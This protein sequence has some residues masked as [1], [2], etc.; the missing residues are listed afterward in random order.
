MKNLLVLIL[1]SIIAF[2]CATTEKPTVIVTDNSDE[3]IEL[4]EPIEEPRIKKDVFSYKSSLRWVGDLA[5]AANCVVNKKSFEDRVRAVRS[6]DFSNSNGDEVYN[7]LINFKCVA[8]TY[9][10]RWYSPNRTKVIATTWTNERNGNFYL[11]LRVHPRP[12]P[13]MINTAIHECLHKVGYSH[14]NNSPVG[15]ENSVNYK[16]GRIAEEESQGCY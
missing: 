12:M 10:T 2:S 8:R 9:K 16:V 6:F 11:N 4:P 7:R 5:K 1:F 15:K 14:G 3:F 13:K